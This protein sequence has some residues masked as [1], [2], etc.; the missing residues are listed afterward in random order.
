MLSI[1]KM[2]VKNTGTEPSQYSR[3]RCWTIISI[4]GMSL[5]AQGTTAV[6]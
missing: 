5:Y 1:A 2:Q 6:Y 4:P 3:V